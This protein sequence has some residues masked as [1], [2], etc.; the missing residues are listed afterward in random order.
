MELRASAR[1]YEALRRLFPA[2]IRVYHTHLD[3]EDGVD[4]LFDAREVPLAE[5]PEHLILAD[6]HQGLLR[7]RAALR[8]VV[9]ACH[10]A[11]FNRAVSQGDS[12]RKRESEEDTST[13]S[14]GFLDFACAQTRIFKTRSLSPREPDEM[15]NDTYAY[16]RFA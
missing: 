3:S 8:R 13:L 1:L 11:R 10:F 14:L 15:R 9:R 12:E 2:A 4:G 6:A 16:T 5:G 7:D